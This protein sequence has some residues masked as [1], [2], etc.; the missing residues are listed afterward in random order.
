[1]PVLTTE[2]LV[3]RPLSFDDA[4]SLFPAFAE[5]TNMRFWSRGP[6]PNIAELRGY[7]HHNVEG[8]GV[9]CFAID[10]AEAPN[11]AV[12]W[13]ALIDRKSGE[14]EMGFILRPDAQGHGFAREAATRVLAHA[15]DTREIRRV[16]ADVDPENAASIAVIE[17]LGMVYEGHL[18][19]TWETHIGVRDSLIYA[20]IR[21]P[22]MTGVNE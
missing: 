20:A 13:V 4:P 6:L 19:A 22:G 10:R 9:Q 2:R 5:D 15:L 21:L 7:M 18:R 14:A 1:M 17:A 12:G 3:L 11:D 16:F 8:E